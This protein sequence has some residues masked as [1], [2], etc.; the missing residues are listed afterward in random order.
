MR[1]LRSLRRLLRDVF[2]LAREQKAWWLV[3]LLV[4]L[5]L[6]AGLVVATQ[7]ATPL[8]YTIF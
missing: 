6:I 4:T 8:L 2:G 7:S 5:L 1:A 3:P